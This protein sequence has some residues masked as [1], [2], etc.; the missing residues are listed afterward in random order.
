VITTTLH[1]KLQNFV[2][3]QI[4]GITLFIIAA[5]LTGALS[6]RFGAKTLIMGGTL[7]STAGGV[8]MCIYA[9]DGGSNVVWV[10]LIFLPLNMG[11]GLRG[12]PGFH[13]ALVAT[14]GDDA[15]GSAIILV[16]ILLTT[17]AGTAAT[18]PFIVQGLV[19][20]AAPA[21]IFSIAAVLTL[22]SA[23]PV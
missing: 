14:E 9:I 12:P 17:A 2:I 23:R 19:S 15:R 4:S 8:L 18:A 3:M 13:A 16:A 1:G 11:L 10:T 5:N 6:R 22:L 20:I 21:A 7:L